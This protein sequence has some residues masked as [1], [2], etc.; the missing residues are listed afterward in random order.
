MDPT[1][2]SAL[3]TRQSVKV[4][5]AAAED[6]SHDHHHWVTLP[7]FPGKV[8]GLSPCPCS[9]VYSWPCDTLASISFVGR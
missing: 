3:T 2:D 6:H 1:E 8:L 9:S 4:T 5:K 7:N